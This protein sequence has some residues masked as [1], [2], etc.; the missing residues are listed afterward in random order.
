MSTE[1]NKKLAAEF[2]ARFSANDIAGAL[3]T[4]TED[5]TWWIAGKPEQLPAAGEYSKERIARLFHNMDGRL[6]DGL[7]LTVK[8]AIAEDDKVA[9]EVE[10]YGELRNG[11]V[12]NQEYHLRMT[13]RD[14]KISAVREYLDT[15]HVFATWFQP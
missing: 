11:R 5:A 13:I 7:K 3:A 6:K 1:D 12:Y 9:V 10:S 14:G 15:Q 2:F 8:S 4:M